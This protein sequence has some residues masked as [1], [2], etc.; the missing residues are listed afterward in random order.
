MCYY[1]LYI[2]LGCGHPTT[3]SIPVR[4]CSNATRMHREEET[5]PARLDVELKTTSTGVSLDLNAGS[6][7]GL[8]SASRTTAGTQAAGKSSVEPCA[9]GRFH[10]LH[11]V[12]LERMCAD[13]AHERE[14]RLRALEE[15]TNDIK[16]DPARSQIKHSRGFVAPRPRRPNVEVVS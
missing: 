12:K 11:T 14:E 8:R 15:T 5:T 2:F 10:P 3:S 9:E 1:R 4:Y 16:L 13:C 6:R 7:P